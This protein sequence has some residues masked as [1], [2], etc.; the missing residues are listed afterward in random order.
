VVHVSAGEAEMNRMKLEI[1]SLSVVSFATAE[2]I[3][4]KDVMSGATCTCGCTLTTAC[5]NCT[6]IEGQD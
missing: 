3:V 2:K 1:D 5:S 6:L 4:V